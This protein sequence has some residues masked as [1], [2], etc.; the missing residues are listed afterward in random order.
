MIRSND[1]FSSHETKTR[2]IRMNT[3]MLN[4]FL[5]F[6]RKRN[7]EMGW[8]FH[9]LVLLHRPITWFLQSMEAFTYILPIVCNGFNTRT[10]HEHQQDNS[11][12][13]KV[14]QLY[15]VWRKYDKIL[16]YKLTDGRY[17]LLKRT[18][19]MKPN[20]VKIRHHIHHLATLLLNRWF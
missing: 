19:T 11:S 18:S 2:A 5:L 10:G 15:F 12:A 14:Q 8:N 17:G 9:R 7:N 4:A 1:E 20:W 3:K 6:S 16:C 13:L